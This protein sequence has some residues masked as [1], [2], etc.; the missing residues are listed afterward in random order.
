MVTAHSG[1]P[2]VAGSVFPSAA[3]RGHSPQCSTRVIIIIVVI[4]IVIIIVICVIVIIVICY[5]GSQISVLYNFSTHHHKPQILESPYGIPKSKLPRFMLLGQTE[6]DIAPFLPSCSATRSCKFG[7]NVKAEKGWP[8][9]DA[10]MQYAR[11]KL[12]HQMRWILF[13]HHHTMYLQPN[14]CAS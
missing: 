5:P 10:Y 3:T 11:R 14:V 2:S 12:D 8:A 9:L 4:V 13:S 7:R 6:Y 1:A